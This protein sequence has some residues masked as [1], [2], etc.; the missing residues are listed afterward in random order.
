MLKC[1]QCSGDGVG[2]HGI[3]VAG[4]TMRLGLWRSSQG[5]V[6]GKEGRTVRRMVVY[7]GIEGGMLTLCSK[8]ARTTVQG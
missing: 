4:K 8:C 3:G 6:L 1:D 5:M 7:C 2:D